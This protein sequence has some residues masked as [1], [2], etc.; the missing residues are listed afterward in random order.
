MSNGFVRLKSASLS[1]AGGAGQ[2][3]SYL[4]VWVKVKN[5]A[6]SKDVQIHYR[7]QFGS[8]WQNRSL[9]WKSNYGNY[10]LFALDPTLD[11]G[12]NPFVEFAISFASG[13]ATYWDNNNSANYSLT[14]FATALT[15]DNNVIL[16]SANLV[17]GG[18]PGSSYITGISGEIFVNNLFY[19]KNVG[20]RHS[21][22]GW[23]S[24]L[25]IGASYGQSL[26]GSLERWLFGRNISP[27]AFGRGEFAVYCQNRET[28]QYFWDNNF[29][30][31]YDLRYQYTLE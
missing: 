29:D 3:H 24:Y 28:G 27:Q 22:N 2:L 5:I 15:G 4:N 23:I 11:F 9:T 19:H 8:L 10:D 20:I 17:F 12:G 25:D 14:P 30:Q 26:G 18:T 16:N 6:Y 7:G 1:L 31:N 21:D 13:G